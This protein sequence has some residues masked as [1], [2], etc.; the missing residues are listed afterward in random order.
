MT[1]VKCS[2]NRNIVP[3]SAAISRVFDDF[4]PGFLGNWAD[5]ETVS[6][7]P[8]VDVHEGDN[9]VVLKADMP[10]MD[11]KDIKVVVNDGLL[12]ITGERTES[13]EENRKGFTRSERYMGRFSRSF[14]LPAWA[15]GS[16]V[17]A[18]YKNGVLTVTIPK[19]EA[20]RPKE[21][22]VHVG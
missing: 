19:S 10:G 1:L 8:F 17:A 16:K 7:R 21:I 11:K 15:D 4:M 6:V 5:G 22:E 3:F 18:D 2:P 13:R 12:T 14:N 20:A 9:E